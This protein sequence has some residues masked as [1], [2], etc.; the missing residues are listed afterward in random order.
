MAMMS[1]RKRGPPSFLRIDTPVDLPHIALATGDSSASALSS[2]ASEADYP[3]FNRPN[4]PRSLQNMKKLSLNLGSG[5]SST[6]SLLSLGP[7]SATSVASS[8]VQQEPSHS[9]KSR[10]PSIVSLPAS[11]NPMGNKGFRKVEDGSPTLPY[12]DGPIQIF[13]G[14][15]LGSEDNAKDFVGLRNRGIKSVLNVAKE[16]LTSFDSPQSQALRAFASTPNLSKVPKGSDPTFFPAHLSSGR[17]AMHYLKL[18]W[19]HGQQDLVEHGFPEAMYFVDAALDRG[20]GVL[21]H[22]QCGISRS[23]T[24]VIALVM[25]AAAERSPSVPSEIWALKGMQGAYTFVKEKS[26]W[27]GPNMSLI[28]QLLEYEKVLKG[29]NGEL[30][31][32]E[33]TMAD[34]DE[35]W[36]RQRRLLD[37]I[38]TDDENDQESAAVMREAQALDKA[39]EDRVLA[40]KASASSV[41]SSGSG[42]GMGAAWRNR[43]ARK[44]AG[45]IA[46]NMTNG[47]S[48]F[49]EDLV[50]EDEEQELL[51]IGG[52]FDEDRVSSAEPDSTSSPEDDVRSHE[53]PRRPVRPPPSA[54]VWKTT[55]TLPKPPM[56]V[57]RSSFDLPPAKTKR[58]PAPIGILPAVPSSPIRIVVD[59]EDNKVKRTARRTTAPTLLVLPRT[60]TESKKPV[61]PPLHLRSN[62][63][64]PKH[65]SNTPL[66]T[67]SQTLFVFPPSPTLTTRTPSA[68]TLTSTMGDGVPFPS[69][70]TPRVSTFRSDGRTRSFIGLAPTPT[71]T[72]FSK[73][74]VRGFIAKARQKDRE[75]ETQGSSL[76]NANNKRPL[77][78]TPATSNSP[79]AAGPS[80]PKPLAPN[81]RFGKYFEYDLSKMVNSKGGFLVEDGQ[82]V[83]EE[84]IRKE[85][86]RERQR[87]QKN[88]EPPVFLDP[89][90]NP[91]CRECGTIS[92]DH[93][94]RKTFGCL[95]CKN[96]QNDNPEKYSLLTKTECKQDYLLTDPELRDEE[97]LPHMLKANPHK[98]TFANMM[99]YVRYQVEEFAWK[100]WGS[101]EALD[102]EYEKRVAEKSKKKNRKFE[103]SLR[104]LRRRTKESS[105]QRRKD[106]EHKH[107]FGPSRTDRGESGQQCYFL[108]SASVSTPIV[109]LVERIRDGRSYVTRNVKALQNGRVVFMM[110][111]SFHKPE[112]W[113]PNVE[114]S[115]PIVPKPD[116]CELEEHRFSA[117]L[118]QENLHPRVAQ[119][120]REVI[121]ERTRSPIAIKSAVEADASIKGMC[122]LSY[123]SDLYLLDQHDINHLSFNFLLRVG[124]PGFL[125][126]SFVNNRSDSFHCGDW[127]LYVMT[128]P[129]AA[130]GRGAVYGQVYTESGTLVAVTTQEGVIRADRQGPQE[131]KL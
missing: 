38:P 59:D 103:D 107:V 113:Q 62:L 22:C 56:T 9:A 131:A 2:A 34:E 105:W 93:A 10:R 21:I 98:S 74:D 6:A 70:L 69:Q 94:Y 86:E 5:H 110:I 60:R 119:I 13:P 115:M 88:M 26:K 49:S 124:A 67:P 75:W 111:C 96:C 7:A 100:K 61:P 33:S 104:D 112:P 53:T 1:P 20:E 81:V 121:S 77:S 51:G 17:P 31:G 109:Y 127:L 95:V 63:L 76:P 125:F 116:A 130:S 68:M 47:S 30:S 117:L 122:I 28:Y 92:I 43:Y 32:S 50:E 129:R 8:S 4:K 84:L 45:S 29:D 16:V 3:P 128:C 39:M 12:A 71:T 58:R 18:Q 72:A 40:R 90:L 89:D 24:M 78:V 41:A 83:D 106:S 42:V 118:N 25:R 36:G 52:G 66:A 99:L 87:I 73:V 82:E 65:Q 102:A 15:W 85:K 27:V 57:M 101:P 97:V 79:T 80:K 44:R 46:S 64:K 14:V 11:A 126:F 37:E 123:L 120:Y 108:L 23:A 48:V 114:W 55:F 54:P 91:K 35:E 19:S